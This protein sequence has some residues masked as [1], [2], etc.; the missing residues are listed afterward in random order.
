[1]DGNEGSELVFGPDCTARF[2]FLYRKAYQNESHL[3]A[4]HELESKKKTVW[5]RMDYYL[6]NYLAC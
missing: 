5:S 6:S 3:Y 4:L 2:V 1:M